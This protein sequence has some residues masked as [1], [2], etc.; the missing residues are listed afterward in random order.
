M[1]PLGVLALDASLVAARQSAA[2][3]TFAV[4]SRFQLQT[5]GAARIAAFVARLRRRAAPVA[6]RRRMVWQVEWY[7]VADPTPRRLCRDAVPR[8]HLRHGLGRRGE[9]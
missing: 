4:R 3:A 6:R 1:S 8:R 9:K 7:P 5:R 2:L